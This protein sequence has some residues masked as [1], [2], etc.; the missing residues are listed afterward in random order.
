MAKKRA[1]K[2]NSDAHEFKTISSFQSHLQS[3]LQVYFDCNACK[4]VKKNSTQRDN[5]NMQRAFL[6]LP[7]IKI[8]FTTP[9][10]TQKLQNK[11]V[12]KIEKEK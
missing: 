1:Q 12:K 6:F 2:V 11:H 3:Y 8:T 5:L 7:K 4:N 10:S 9:N